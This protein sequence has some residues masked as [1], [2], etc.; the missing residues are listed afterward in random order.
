M[1]VTI[2]GTNGIETNTDTG[3][4]KV[5]A[6]DDLSLYHGG[7]DS[8]INNATG[9]FY[10]QGENQLTIKANNNVEI[11]KATGDEAMAKFIPDGAVE[12]YH[13]NTKQC[14]TSANGLAFILL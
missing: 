3:R 7:T 9:H 14:E 8:V 6:S 12:L 4:I 1:A 11:L 10:I 5:G 13:N 2:N